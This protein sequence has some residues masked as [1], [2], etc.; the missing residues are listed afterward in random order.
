[1]WHYIRTQKSHDL[2]QKMMKTLVMI[3]MSVI[4][5]T[6]EVLKGES[7][8]CGV[9]LIHNARWCCLLCFNKQIVNLQKDFYPLTTF[10]ISQYVVLG[11]SWC[12]F[13]ILSHL[14]V[15]QK[16]SV[17]NQKMRMNLI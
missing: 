15:H 9:V 5:C 13:R 4:N 17:V 12:L 7:K 1:M 11:I 2:L 16:N 14:K 8:L 6:A 3:L 10:A